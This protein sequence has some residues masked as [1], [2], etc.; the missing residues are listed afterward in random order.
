[1]SN[2]VCIK[3]KKA[4]LS[5]LESSVLNDTICSL[6]VFILVQSTKGRPIVKS[7]HEPLNQLTVN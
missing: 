3:D 6:K 7:N 5:L 1:M 2:S 4:Q